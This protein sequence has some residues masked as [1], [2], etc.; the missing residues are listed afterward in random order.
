[1]AKI[2]IDGKEFEVNGH[3]TIIEAALEHGIEIPH[4]P[5]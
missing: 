2:T 3:K 4:V 5:R 1:M